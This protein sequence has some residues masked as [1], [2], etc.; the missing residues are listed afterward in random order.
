MAVAVRRID[1]AKVIACLAKEFHHGLTILVVVDCRAHAHGSAMLA[2]IGQLARVRSATF[3]DA[4]LV[5]ICMDVMGFARDPVR[6]AQ[7]G[8]SSPTL[9][10]QVA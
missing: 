5:S 6:C 3:L 2:C 7:I 10:L 9:S 1:S 4:A 8:V